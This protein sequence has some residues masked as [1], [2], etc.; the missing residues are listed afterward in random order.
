MSISN[1]NLI[2][3]NRN[4]INILFSELFSI[5][6]KKYGFK[7]LGV[8]VFRSS[9][10]IIGFNSIFLYPKTFESQAQVMTSSSD[11]SSLGLSSISSF[12]ANECNF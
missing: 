8:L 2:F 7:F 11:A 9:F 1:S 6:Y 10:F 4:K 5:S 12:F 3:T